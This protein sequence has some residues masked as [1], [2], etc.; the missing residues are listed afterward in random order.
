MAGW[1]ALLVAAATWA[2]V[3]A[4]QEGLGGE[5][6]PPG[7]LGAALARLRGEPPVPG[8][9]WRQ[10]LAA[11]WRPLG[12]PVLP[13]WRAVALAWLLLTAGRYLILRHWPLAMLA[14]LAAL[15]YR[16]HL[17]QRWRRRRLEL[18]NYQLRDALAAIAASLRA[19]ASLVVACERCVDDLQRL[20]PHQPGAPVIQEFA[21]IRQDLRLG[22]SLEDALLRFRE[23]VPLTDVADFVHAALLCQARGGDLAGV[24]TRIAAVI[25]DKVAV[26]H[27]VQVLTAGKRLEAALLTLAPPALVGL[28]ALTAPE[29][30]APLHQTLA[31]RILAAAGALMLLGAVLLGR[32]ALD[33]EI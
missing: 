5:S 30:L 22:C 6:L 26:Q 24:M 33:I 27:Q 28:L 14:G 2:A 15:P 4:L 13:L 7:A 17:L 11:F 10:A 16:G 20:L 9:R 3:R 31:G 19:G 12:V 23:R 21:R 18:L 32:R 1:L 25:G 8:A 29:Y